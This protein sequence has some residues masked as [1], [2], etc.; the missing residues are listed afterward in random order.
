MV[1][2][3]TT[4]FEALALR[5]HDARL[6]AFVDLYTAR[7]AEVW[8]RIAGGRVHA[9]RELL[10]EG[11]A[12]RLDGTFASSDGLDRLVLAELL[13][14]PARTLP[15]FD[16]QPFPRPPVIA[17][18]VEAFG[19][20]AAAELHWRG[21]WSALI[22]GGT[23]VALRR[24]EL[25]EVALPDGQRFLYTWP[26]A[27]GWQQPAPAP[28]GGAGVRAGRHVTALAPAAAAVLFH[29]LLAHPL[30][31]DLLQR[32]ASPLVGRQ[33]ER[34]FALPLDVDDDPQARHLPGSFAI[35]DEGV[36][37]H[38]RPLV[39]GGVLVGM[40]CDRAAAAARGGTAGSA[41]RAGVHSPPRPRVS[42]LVVR[43][44]AGAADELRGAASIEIASLAGG[45]VEPRTGM[46]SLAVRSA[47]ALRRGR[48]VHPLAPFALAGTV[49]AVLAG[50]KA[51][52]GPG[53]A[54]AEPG[55]CSKDGEVVPTGAVAPWVLLAGME[56]R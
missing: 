49:A 24:P 2:P 55:W 6:R 15:A 52:A 25:L 21:G 39:R 44:A 14:V 28:E 56:A 47:W 35:D 40:L 3:V 18:V 32:G 10:R 20:D 46:V 36:A 8:W 4:G 54:T 34:L 38:R 41:R 50:V 37:A 16:L 29:E 13:G 42:N 31:G 19:G 9:R 23:A 5:L 51:L 30:E 7:T 1:T 27:E 45:T 26:L 48:R 22:A 33:G 53:E 11:A 43:A 12:V 17:S